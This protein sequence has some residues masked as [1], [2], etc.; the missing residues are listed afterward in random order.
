MTTLSQE[1]S[2]VVNAHTM[3]RKNVHNIATYK[4]KVL[5]PSTNKKLGKRV[6]KGR[7]AGFPMYTLTLEERATCPSACEHWADCYGNNMPFGHRFE[8]EGLMPRLEIELD[9]LD[10]RHPTGYLVR[11]HVLGDFYSVSYV[12]FWAEQLRERPALAVYG[13][14]R[15]HPGETVIGDAL[16]DARG[17][18]GFSR[19]SIRFSTLPSDTLSANT[20]HNAGKDGIVCPV[21]LDKTDSCG[22]CTLCWSAFK[23]ITF[24]DH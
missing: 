14:S 1:H 15:N 17:E 16:S 21:Q 13:Y 8:I 2:A 12:E 24:L 23:P 7:Y 9:A 10:K 19:F 4:H 11:L 3:Y 18:L 20:E 22:T 6:T 5:K